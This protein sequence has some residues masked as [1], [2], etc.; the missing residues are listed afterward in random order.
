MVSADCQ[1]ELENAVA[2][3]RASLRALDASGSRLDRHAAR[4]K[5]RF[6]TQILSDHHARQQGSA[7]SGPKAGRVGPQGGRLTPA[8]G[9]GIGSSRLGEER[10]RHP[11]LGLTRR[12]EDAEQGHV[13]GRGGA[14]QRAEASGEE[15][16]ESGFSSDSM[17]DSEY[18]ATWEALTQGRRRD[19]IE[20][21]KTEDHPLPPARR[22]LGLL[23][24]ATVASGSIM[25]LVGNLP[26]TPTGRQAMP[27]ADRRGSGGEI[28]GSTLLG[29][30]A[31]DASLEQSAS[32]AS[33][34]KPATPRV[35]VQV[36][37][38]RPWSAPQACSWG[39]AKQLAV[40]NRVS[41]RQRRGS[42]PGPA[43]TASYASPSDN[44]GSA[45]PHSVSRRG[46]AGGW[47]H[48]PTTPRELL[49]PGSR[50]RPGCKMGGAL[51][52][53]QVMADGR[54]GQ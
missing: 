20:W 1:R 7:R 25:K 45:L 18:G 32:T 9:T 24:K 37:T 54:S 33:P 6:L 42:R 3:V 15:S 14:E 35:Q 41:A 19:S 10:R 53:A 17:S 51:K 40:Q 8:G 39:T 36:S 43:E 4:K 23:V 52:G 34:R 11:G 30:F 31:S 49:R 13:M 29:E 48:V 28:L 50:P 26:A 47:S 12:A 16:E 22:R 27:N 21:L 2:S 5:E 44:T 38:R 46:G